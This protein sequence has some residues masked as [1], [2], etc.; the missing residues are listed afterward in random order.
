[1]DYDKA[2]KDF[3]EAIKLSPSFAW[4]FHNRGMAWSVQKEYDKA[5]NDYDESIR[6]A[7]A[8][9]TFLNRGGAWGEKKNY[10][11]AIKDFD[12]AIRLDP[13]DASAFHNR[14]Y[15]WNIKR[16]YDKA[17][18]DFN[19]AIRLDPKDSHAFNNRGNAQQGKKEYDKAIKDYDEAIRL[20]PKFTW[21]INNR[22]IAWLNKKDYEKAIKDFDGAIRVEPKFAMAHFHRALVQMLAQRPGAADR[23]KSVIDL[24]AW[25]EEL[26][27]YAVI[28]GHFAARQATDE[29]GAKKFL[30]DATGKLDDA[31][32]YPVVQFLR[33]EIE[34][35]VLLAQATDDDKRTDARCFLGLDLA[36]K[37]HTN[38]ALV[39]FRW[40]KDHGNTTFV[41]YTIAV[42][43]LERLE[44]PRKSP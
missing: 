6:L 13:K 21:P 26:A 27:T 44:A 23:F 38:E 28:L 35:P 40:V 42:T 3:D 41:E 19:E 39:H 15:A 2:I 25:K 43:E 24:Q 18:K 16:D 1:M 32:P 14:G 7:P 31:W 37:G 34:E 5:I 11:K 12:E 22:G 17:I 9:A 33:G 29:A 20:D 8:S 30:K 10:D 36:L 4:A